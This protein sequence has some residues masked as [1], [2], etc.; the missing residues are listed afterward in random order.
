MVIFL[1]I[2]L[3]Y[4]RL[5]LTVKRLGCILNSSLRV[6]ITL[7]LLLLAGKSCLDSF[8]CRCECI[9]S[10]FLRLGVLSDCIQHLLNWD[11]V[12]FVL[13]RAVVH[14]TA[15]H[16]MMLLLLR[17]L[18]SLTLLLLGQTCLF[19]FWEYSDWSLKQVRF[20]NLLELLE[21]WVWIH[22]FS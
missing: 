16:Q 19:S 7:Y 11:F 17:W 6:P 13:L 14:W 8:R 18:I 10:V 12:G 2:Q 15:F 22:V 3:G 5:Q 4:G 1:G 9:Q 20:D 21:F